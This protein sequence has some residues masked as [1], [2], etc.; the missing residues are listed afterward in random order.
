MNDLI[1][2]ILQYSRAGQQDLSL[3]V[4]ESRDLV[5]D[6]VSALSPPSNVACLVSSVRPPFTLSDSAEWHL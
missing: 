5:S 4:I 3:T 6:V 2:G 1:D